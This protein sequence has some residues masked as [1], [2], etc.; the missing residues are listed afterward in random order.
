MGTGGKGSSFSYLSNFK[1]FGILISNPSISILEYPEASEPCLVFRTPYLG[2]QV[3][4]LPLLGVSH[5]SLPCEPQK[6]LQDNQSIPGLASLGQLRIGDFF[7][8]AIPQAFIR[9]P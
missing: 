2:C 9:L 6:D 1:L 7:I 8:L 4:D 3:V 5:F